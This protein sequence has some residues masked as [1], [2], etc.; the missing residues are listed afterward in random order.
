MAAEN[1]LIDMFRQLMRRTFAALDAL[2]NPGAD[3]NADRE[4]NNRI[5][6]P[7]NPDVL[8]LI[9]KINDSAGQESQRDIAFQFTN[10]DRKHAD[11]LLRQVR[12]YPDLLKKHPKSLSARTA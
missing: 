3:S 7:E 4:K 12:R 5:R 8:R 9:K 11:S 2:E 6:I 1:A 10:G